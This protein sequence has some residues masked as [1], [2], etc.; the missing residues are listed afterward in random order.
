MEGGE[1]AGL[2]GLL[3]EALDAGAFST[4]ETHYI[5]RPVVAPDATSVLEGFGDP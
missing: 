5:A 2:T 3:R 4:T 1:P